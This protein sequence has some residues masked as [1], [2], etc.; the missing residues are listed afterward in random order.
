MHELNA[1]EKPG[2][3]VS[4]FVT[5]IAL[6]CSPGSHLEIQEEQ[7]ESIAFYQEGWRKLTEGKEQQSHLRKV[8]P[9]VNNE[10]FILTKLLLQILTA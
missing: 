8:H 6:N 4:I 5:V 3:S 7:E 1:G 10:L 9:S 2:I